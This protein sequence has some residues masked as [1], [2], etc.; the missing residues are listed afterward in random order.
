MSKIAILLGMFVITFGIRFV[1]L[2]L[3]GR[4]ELPEWAKE[5]LVYIPPCVLTAIV[6]PS[7]LLDKAGSVD[8]SLGNHFLLVGVFALVVSLLKEN[9]LFSI[10]TSMLLYG[11]LYTG[12]I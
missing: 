5:A 2:A 3:A 8:L 12:L 7:I 10:S 9:L 11:A 1:F 4:L 6:V